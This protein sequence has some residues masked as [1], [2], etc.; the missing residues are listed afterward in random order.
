MLNIKEI[1]FLFLNHHSVTILIQNLDA[2][3]MYVEVARVFDKYFP[4]IINLKKMDMVKIDYISNEQL[5]LCTKAL[6][7]LVL[8]N[9]KTTFLNDLKIK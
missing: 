2:H 9:S 5:V 4:Y 8:K 1:G 3:R 6:Y 7:N